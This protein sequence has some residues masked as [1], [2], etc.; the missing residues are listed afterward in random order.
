MIRNAD[1]N[2]MDSILR[3]YSY[4]REFMRENGNPNQWDDNFPPLSIIEDDIVKKQ[5]FVYDDCGG[6]HG[7]FAFIIGDDETYAHIEQGEWLSC[8]KY[9]TIH[10]IATDGTIHGFL[11]QTV[12]FCENRI[13]HLRIDTHEDNV[14]MRH[15][16]VECGFRQC[17][18]IRV[19]GGS[20]RIA[21]EKI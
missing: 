9:G 19:R 20:P 3:I 12:M 15:L 16:I 1:F 18:I 2:D 4:A 11:R 6:I 21:Y 8:G 14:I 5:L 10:R 7:V 13:P 17:G